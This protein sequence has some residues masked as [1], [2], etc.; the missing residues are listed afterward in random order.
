M[1]PA[2]IRPG[3]SANLPDILEL[4]RRSAVYWPPRLRPAKDLVPPEASA[5]PETDPLENEARSEPPKPAARW[6]NLARR[7]GGDQC[8]RLCPVGRDSGPPV[9]TES[10]R[11]PPGQPADAVTAALIERAKP[12]RRNRTASCGCG[13]SGANGGCSGRFGVPSPFS[14]AFHLVR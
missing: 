3:R 1:R 9:C 12:S 11:V 10:R 8:R 7:Y 6:S 14:H 2:E 5:L 13:G 4:A